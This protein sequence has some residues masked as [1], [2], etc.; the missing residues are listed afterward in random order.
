MQQQ[1]H[2]PELPRTS[3]LMRR[4][5][6]RISRLGVTHESLLFVQKQEWVLLLVGKSH[7]FCSKWELLLVECPELC[8]RTL[9]IL[10]RVERWDPCCSLY[11]PWPK[12]VKQLCVLIVVDCLIDRSVIE[13]QVVPQGPPRVLVPLHFDYYLLSGAY[14]APPRWI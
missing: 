1:I 13:L 11:F 10:Q 8:D 12:V 7:Y 5:L 14:A 4:K 3:L 9:A 6:A 2:Q